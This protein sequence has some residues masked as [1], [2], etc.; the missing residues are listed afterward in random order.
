[1]TERLTLSPS[2]SPDLLF[3]GQKEPGAD[4]LMMMAVG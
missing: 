1:M 4:G 2:T 3:E